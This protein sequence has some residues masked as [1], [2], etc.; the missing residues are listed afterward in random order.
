M[1][2]GLYSKRID[3]TKSSNRS[4]RGG[5]KWLYPDIVAIEDLT[6]D[7]TNQIKQLVEARKD[8]ASS[9]WSFE[10][11]ILLN[12]ANVRE[13]FSQALS[14]SAWA[15]FGYLVATEIAGDNETMK[16]YRMLYE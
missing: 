12:R 1:P 6:Q 11:K 15:N 16:E 2:C 3:E 13:Y 9:L 7:W 10:V 8:K 14:N 5:N 4:A